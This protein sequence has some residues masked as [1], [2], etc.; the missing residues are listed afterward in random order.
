MIGTTG[1]IGG[2]TGDDGRR[3]LRLGIDTG[4]TFTDAVLLDAEDRLLAAA[5]VPTTHGEPAAGIAEAVD[6]V[7]AAG[8]GKG[9]VGLVGL[10]TSLATD[11]LAEGRGG[12]AALVLI[13]L[14][15]ALLRRARLGE[16]LG[17][18]PLVLLPDDRRAR[19]R[20]GAESAVAEAVAKLEAVAG[21][22]EAVAV[23]GRFALRDPA[24]ER[25][26]ADLLRRRSG[27][28]VTC[29]HELSPGLD[30]GRRA[31]LTLLNARLLPGMR[32]F[33]D[34]VRDCLEARGIT[35]PLMV[36]RGDGALMRPE[37][38]LE[39]P[40]QTLLS[41]AAAAIVGAARLAGMPNAVIADM[42][43]ATTDI[44]V[45]ED[46]R[47]RLSPEGAR[48]AGLRTMV[49]AIDL[50]TV[51]LGGD[52]EV[53][54]DATGR[55]AIGPGRR[56]PLARLGARHP[57]I[58]AVLERQLAAPPRP[59]DALFALRAG[60]GRA[61]GRDE[62]RVLAMLE[63]GPVPL[64]EVFA[65]AGDD[66][67]EGLLR[68]GLLRVAGF[69]PTDAAHVLGRQRTGSVAA[70]RLGAALEARR[71]VGGE[72]PADQPVELFA[73]QVFEA[74]EQAVARALAA[75]ALRGMGEEP[76]WLA[77]AGTGGTLAR[78]LNPAAPPPERN[79]LELRFRLMRPLVAVGAPAPLF[80]PRPAV[81]LD[82]ALLIPEAHAV[83]GAIG[84]VLGGVVRRATVVVARGP[85]GSHLLLPGEPPR[86]FEGFETALAAAEEEA[87]RR[88][89]AL[90]EE[91][92][93]EEAAVTVERAFEQAPAEG[94]TMV[95][96]ARITAVARGRPPAARG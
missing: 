23:V 62:A 30:A 88:A 74:C 96:E 79:L 33:L 69:T 77:G 43:G 37:T 3:G 20:A 4:G 65:D 87:A 95:A 49:R 80:F 55:L 35:A 84:A 64:A 50:E 2:V 34:A 45:L 32:K 47:P 31:R 71:P 57:A 90:L 72:A 11:A 26:V 36:V 86:R 78:A 89:R 46:G 93:V 92:G 21:G 5:K 70:A 82:T 52:S 83:C 12:R 66:R 61:Q 17:D 22:V 81:H 54:R 19:G 16:V 10:S 38:A 56:M 58:V 63:R 40:V 14:G 75:A 42:G 51:A 73:R 1:G 8:A 44:A 6:R 24:R 28:P 27:L 25:R 67:F 59:F 13:G 94:G 91:T 39:R 15:R 48:V 7:L 53:R 9:G 41:G 68:R 18:G 29:S 60:Q 85:G 76:S